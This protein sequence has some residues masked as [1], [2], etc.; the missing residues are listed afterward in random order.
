M[1]DFDGGKVGHRNDAVHACDAL[2]EA[3]EDRA[4]VWEAK[5]S[6]SVRPLRGAATKELRCA[7]QGPECGAMVGPAFETR[8]VVGKGSGDVGAAPAEEL[9]R[10]RL[11]CRARWFTGAEGGVEV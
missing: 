6:V 4:F 5:G 9:L 11:E 3:S 2:S 1:G 8:H 10:K 7:L